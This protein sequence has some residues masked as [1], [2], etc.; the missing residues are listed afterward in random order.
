VGY[1]Q[2]LPDA[3]EAH[4]GIEVDRQG[5]GFF[6]VFPKATSAV[7]AANREIA[8]SL[9]MTPKTVEVHLSS[10]Y[11]KLGIGSRTQLADALP[12]D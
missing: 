5:D 9:F 4:D 8:Q 6:F 12:S 11:R 2:N 1:T 10:A 7:R 3:I